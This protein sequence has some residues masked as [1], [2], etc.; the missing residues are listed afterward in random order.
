[1][2]MIVDDLLRNQKVFYPRRSAEEPTLLV[3]VPGAQLACFYHQRYPAA[4]VL[5]HFHGNGELAAEYARDHAEWFWSMG[6]NVCFAEYRGY[7]ASTGSPAL[8][9]MLGDGEKI[10]QALG[11]APV[12][13]VAFG[14][15]L[16]SVYAVELARRFPRLAGVILESG[17]ADVA[18]WLESRVGAAGGSLCGEQE[19]VAEINSY[20]NLKSTLTDYK[21]GLLVLHAEHDH[22]VDR[23]NAE[24]FYAWA[25]TTDKKLVVLPQGNHNTILMANY[26][27]YMA[28]VEAFLQRAGIATGRKQKAERSRTGRWWRF[29]E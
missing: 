3:E 19:L 29:W 28:E 27:T 23:S 11:I 6:V 22:M 18:S 4:G 9:A 1:M 10:V 13:I 12:R 15:S 17:I 8:G 2:A 16:G 25:G 5:L 21:G 24:R 26:T 14:R 20:F 7:G